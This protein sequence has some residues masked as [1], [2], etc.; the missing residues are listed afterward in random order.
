MSFKILTTTVSAAVASGGTFTY[1]YPAGL[2]AGAFLNGFGHQL[3]VGG[4]QTIYNAPADFTLSFGATTIT[5]TY[6]GST[7]IPANSVVKLQAEIQG[8]D[9]REQ[10]RGLP[11]ST[12]RAA[13]SPAVLINL[14]APA[15]GATNNIAAAQAVAGAAN[16]TL[17][18]TAISGGLLTN[19]VPRGWQVVSSNAGD[20]TQTAIATGTDEYGVAMTEKLTLNGTTGV[21]GKKAF[22]TIT[23]IAMSAATTGNVSAGT[24]NV[25]GLPVFLAQVTAVMKESQD[26]AAP[27]AGTIVK[28]DLTK[29]SNTTG[30]V[31]GTYA[32]NATPDGAK[33]FQLYASIPDPQYRGLVQV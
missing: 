31:R 26:G 11:A 18:G 17:N 4:H 25:L 19:A 28:G 21:I 32:P 12:Q 8:Q 13:I 6:N 20:T 5:V 33:V 15:A 24:S 27:T 22:A 7:T 3:S 14:G 30:D 23:Q 2:D 10:W 16:L 29:P 9:D 1:T